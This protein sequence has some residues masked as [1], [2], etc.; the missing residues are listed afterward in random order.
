MLTS[1]HVPA[2]VRGVLS[3]RAGRERQALVPS[4]PCHAGLAGDRRRCAR[5]RPASVPEVIADHARGCLVF[6]RRVAPGRLLRHLPGR[7]RRPQDEGRDAVGERRGEEAG[8]RAAV[9]G[10]EERAPVASRRVQDGRHVR[11]EIFERGC[12]RRC[13]PLGAAETSPIGHDHSVDASELAQ[14]AGEGRVIRVQLDVRQVALQ[15]EQ[16]RLGALEH[17]VGERG[18]A[19]PRV[20]DLR[21]HRVDRRTSTPG[22]GRADARLERASTFRG[23][24]PCSLTYLVLLCIVLRAMVGR[25]CTSTRT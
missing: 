11:E 13:E 18:L 2:L 24:T 19:V 17:L 4:R 3:Y 10:R 8:E 9:A 21:L 6:F 14:E 12:V 25:P 23:A 20:L 15:V 1:V 5:A 7:G 16:A 22:S